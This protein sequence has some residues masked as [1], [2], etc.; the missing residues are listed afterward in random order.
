MRVSDVNYFN[1]GPRLTLTFA[2]LITLIIGGNGLLVWQFHIARLQTDG[3][4]GISEQ[5]IAVLRLQESLL[6]FHQRLDEL[7]QAKDAHLLVTEAEP[8][9]RALLEQTQR[10]RSSVA[11]LP[12]EA[13]VDPA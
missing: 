5:V 2:L 11:R 1:I 3:L 4:T 7:A 13:R 9:R 12:P 6:S 10:T 8:L